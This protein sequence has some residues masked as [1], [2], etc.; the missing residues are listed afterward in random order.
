MY[1]RDSYDE[2]VLHEADQDEKLKDRPCCC[3]CDEHIQEEF[4]IQYNGDWYCK[5]CEDVFFDV[6]RQQYKERVM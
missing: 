2:F 6:L 5:D 1:V 4:A 3:S